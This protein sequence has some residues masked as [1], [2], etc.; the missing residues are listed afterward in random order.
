MCKFR[1]NPDMGNEGPK[2][3]HLGQDAWVAQAV[4]GLLEGE[5][6]GCVVNKQVEVS[7]IVCRLFFLL[8]WGCI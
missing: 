1:V 7:L 5:V 8:L 6:E 2:S 4:Q 3:Y